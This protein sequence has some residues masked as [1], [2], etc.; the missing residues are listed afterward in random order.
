MAL[1]S[2]EV[3]DWKI[4]NFDPVKKPDGPDEE[5]GKNVKLFWCTGARS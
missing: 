3:F 5:F 4:G 1:N 2:F